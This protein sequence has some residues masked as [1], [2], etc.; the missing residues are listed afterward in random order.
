[1]RWAF[2]A[3]VAT[4]AA[5]SAAP[6]IWSSSAPLRAAGLGEDLRDLGF[7]LFG[8]PHE[9]V[10]A[11]RLVPARRRPQLRPVEGD[12]AELYEPG[13]RAQR[14]HLGEQVLE[15]VEVPAAKARDRAVVRCG[16]RREEAER[17]SISREE[18][19]PIE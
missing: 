15:R 7:E 16:V 12:P 11:H 13:P 3:G 9:V 2:G 17:R 19:T 8:L 4:S 10:I 6:A 5:C 18:V 14:Q 1:L